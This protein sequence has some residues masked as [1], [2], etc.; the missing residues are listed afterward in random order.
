MRQHRKQSRKLHVDT[1]QIL[2]YMESK[3]YVLTVWCEAHQ[4]EAYK[5]GSPPPVTESPVVHRL[6]QTLKELDH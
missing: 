5:A 6:W 2:D 3:G 4:E 1:Q